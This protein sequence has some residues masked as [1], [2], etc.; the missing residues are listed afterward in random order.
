MNELNPYPAIA[1]M[2]SSGLLASIDRHNVDGF[3]AE[4]R[5]HL[6]FFPGPNAVRRE[7]HD[8]AVA[9]RELLGDYQ[10]MIDAALVS[11]DAGAELAE[12]FRASATP[13][14]VLLTGSEILEVIPRVR[15][16]SD[17]AA[18][19]RRYLGN[20]PTASSTGTA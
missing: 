20:P 7:A 10:G 8:V 17:Y 1:Q 3:L 9:L 2:C 6:L 13:C 14:L 15:D 19:F 12:R 5:P 4:V 16:W 18:A 11:D